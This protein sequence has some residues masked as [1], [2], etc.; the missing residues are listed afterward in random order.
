MGGG[1]ELSYESG[2]VIIQIAD[3]YHGIT[4]EALQRFP[5]SLFGQVLQYAQ[6]AKDSHDYGGVVLIPRPCP[7]FALI[8]R[9]LEKGLGQQQQNALDLTRLQGNTLRLLLQDAVYFKLPKLA[10]AIKPLLKPELT[11][12]VVTHLLSRPTPRDFSGARLVGLDLSDLDFANFQIKGKETKYLPTTVLECD[13]KPKFI[14][15]DLEW[16]DFSNSTLSKSDFT[17][18]NLSFS[19]LSNS[20]LDSCCFDGSLL[21]QSNF[22]KADLTNVNFQK[23]ILNQTNFSEAQLIQVN[24][25]K[26]N[27]SFSDSSTPTSTAQSPMNSNYSNYS[28]S[29]SSNSSPTSNG[30]TSQSDSQSPTALPPTTCNFERSFFKE[31]NLSETNFTKCIMK[32]AKFQDC[33]LQGAIFDSA[34]LEGAEFKNCNLSLIVASHCNFKAT[35]FIDCDLSG[36]IL[37]HSNL[38]FTHLFS[39]NFTRAQLVGANLQCSELFEFTLS[40]P[41]GKL[42]TKN[43]SIFKETNFRFALLQGTDFHCLD[44]TGADFRDSNLTNAVMVKTITQ[45]ANLEGAI[46]KRRIVDEIEIDWTISKKGKPMA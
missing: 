36:A 42:T 23:A 46:L 24:F 19:N 4:K 44:C 20:I 13:F 16:V 5:D 37:N 25:S 35:K 31:A 32:K 18:A 6:K 45:G 43:P 9:Y 27:V 29:N 2:E 12:E 14:E 39:S 40:E 3:K 7:Q 10:A 11:R 30:K 33:N 26:T 41:E 34:D 15:S 8:K 22:S 38:T 17:K 1:D 28:N 21:L